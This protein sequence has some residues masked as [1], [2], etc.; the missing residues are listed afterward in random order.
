MPRRRAAVA[1]LQP[2]GYSL[3]TRPSTA[4]TPQTWPGLRMGGLARA[5]GHPTTAAVTT[6]FTPHL[7]AQG[8]EG[9]RGPVQGPVRC[10]HRVPAGAQSRRCQGR[11]HRGACSRRRRRAFARR[12][13]VA[14]RRSVAA[15]RE[16]EAEPGRRRGGARG[17][18]GG[19]GSGEPPP[20][21]Y[22]AAPMASA[23]SASGGSGG[24]GRDDSGGVESRWPE[25][26]P[27]AAAAAAAMVGER[28]G[29]GTVGWEIKDRVLL[30][31]GVRAPCSR[32]R[33]RAR[34]ISVVERTGRPRPTPPADPA[35]G[36]WRVWTCAVG[37]VCSGDP[38]G[39]DIQTRAWRG[40]IP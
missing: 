39:E 35:R 40:A 21:P 24:A 5:A 19:G 29:G 23:S 22:P 36:L 3:N 7:L 9:A 31:R 14:R 38:L 11:R 33:R 28:A 30:Q 10:M 27:A 16:H 20:R 1:R 26:P 17:G 8:D 2:L 12:R 32:P 25:S 37:S 34:L 4:T 6:E 18:R 15:V 13:T